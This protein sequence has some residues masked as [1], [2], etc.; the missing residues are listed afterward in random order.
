MTAEEL[1]RRV[2]NHNLV[3]IG[4][5]LGCIPASIL[6]WYLSFGFFRIAFFIALDLFIDNA[7]S[8]SLILA[9]LCM[10]PLL[11]EGVRHTRPLFELSE[12][13]RSGFHEMMQVG[14]DR[15]SAMGFDV[16]NY[17]GLMFVIT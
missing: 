2:G 12:V 13:G 1:S 15:C 17:G 16:A 4:I 7:E 14:Q 5:V 10:I 6:L 8:V 3:Q 11:I 9:W